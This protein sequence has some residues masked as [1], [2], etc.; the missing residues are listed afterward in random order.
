MK[1]LHGLVSVCGFQAND[2]SAGLPEGQSSKHL[3][4]Q[5][6]LV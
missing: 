2:G 1:Q 6:S 3:A 4:T 5:V